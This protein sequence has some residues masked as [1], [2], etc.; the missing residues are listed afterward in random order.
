MQLLIPMGYPYLHKLMVKLLI[1]WIS[2]NDA[3]VGT[4]AIST[5][6]SYSELT[7][8]EIFITVSN[9]YHGLPL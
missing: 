4:V 6:V 8:I 1:T 3:T 2:A 5:A 7:V 9:W